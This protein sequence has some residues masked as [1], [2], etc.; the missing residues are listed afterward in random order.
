[1]LLPGLPDAGIPVDVQVARLAGLALD[2]GVQLRELL[3]RGRGRLVG[4]ERRGNGQEAQAQCRYHVAFHRSILIG[5]NSE[6]VHGT[7]PAAAGVR[8]FAGWH[9][10]GWPVPGG[11]VADGETWSG[12]ESSISTQP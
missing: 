2:H 11:H 10:L 4:P 6:I 12:L 1:R 9:S 5:K 8:A 7:R 3:R